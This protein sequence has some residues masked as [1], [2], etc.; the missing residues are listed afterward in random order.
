VTAKES[1]PREEGQSAKP[2]QRSSLDKLADFTKRIIAVPKEQLDAQ[3]RKE[4]RRKR[5]R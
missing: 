3:R 1:K 2:D 5:K 4:R